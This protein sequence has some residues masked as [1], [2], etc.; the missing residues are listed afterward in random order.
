MLGDAAAEELKASMEAQVL[1][2][3]DEGQRRA[4]EKLA[5][6]VRSFVSREPLS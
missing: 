3:D 5:E 6:D 1:P 4:R 2:A